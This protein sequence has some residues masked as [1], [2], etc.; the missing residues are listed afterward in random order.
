V[1]ESRLPAWWGEKADKKRQNARS[2]A[3]ERRRAE[4]V[5][6]KVQTGSGSSWRAQGDVRGVEYMDEMKFTDAKSYSLKI[7]TW[8]KARKAAHSQG[9]EPR[10][11]IDF[12]AEKLRLV[13]TEEDYPG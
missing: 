8:R 3:Q 1:T 7:T 2:A 13:V 5:G 9:R 10:M 12:P 6:G 11:V 4:D